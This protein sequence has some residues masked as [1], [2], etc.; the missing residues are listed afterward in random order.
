MEI[1]RNN[2]SHQAE[3]S[4]FI[5]KK[6]ALKAINEALKAKGQKRTTWLEIYKICMKSDCIAEEFANQV[7]CMRE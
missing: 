4:E 5:K 7:I 2:R 1:Q 3:I 6:Y